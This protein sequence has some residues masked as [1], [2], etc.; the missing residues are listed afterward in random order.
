MPVSSTCKTI[1]FGFEFHN[2]CNHLLWLG[3]QSGRLVG[4]I[5][6]PPVYMLDCPCARYVMRPSMSMCECCCVSVCENRLVAGSLFCS[7]RVL[8]KSES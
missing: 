7:V 1:P 2:N 4:G 3:W 6:A 5:S 8:S